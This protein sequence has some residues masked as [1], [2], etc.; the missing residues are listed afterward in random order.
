MCTTQS[1]RGKLE[2]GGARERSLHVQRVITKKSAAS[3]DSAMLNA[4]SMNSFFFLQKEGCSG[5]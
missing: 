3:A 5:N 1:A 2:Y 4:W